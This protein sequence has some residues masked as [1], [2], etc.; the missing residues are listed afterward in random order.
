M[1]PPVAAFSP[2]YF[3]TGGGLPVPSHCIQIDRSGPEYLTLAANLKSGVDGIAQMTIEGWHYYD[4]IPT[5]GAIYGVL[6][7]LYGDANSKRAY[8]AA[9]VDV[10]G[11]LYVQLTVNDSSGA[12]HGVRWAVSLSTATWYHMA[13][14]FDSNA[15]AAA[16]QPAF[17]LGGVDQGP[18]DVTL[19]SN[20]LTGINAA[21][22]EFTMGAYK[23]STSVF[24]HNGRLADHRFWNT[25]RTTTQISSSMSLHIAPTTSGLVSN[26]L[27]DQALTDETSTGNDMTFVGTASYVEDYPY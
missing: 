14:S 20:N 19:S 2:T 15:A 23:P 1:T 12:A 27:F 21:V 26:W 25:I 4:T 9:L 17:H 13:L 5:G 8:L 6:C 22:W 16:D 7:N 11:Q 24:G 10:S 3:A 18:P